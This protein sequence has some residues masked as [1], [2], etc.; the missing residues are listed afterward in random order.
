MS[1]KKKNNIIIGSLCAVVLLMVVG[2]AAFSSVLNIK[3]TSKVSSNWNVHISNISVLQTTGSATNAEDPSW[4]ALTGTFKTNL[5]S[6]GDAMEYSV[7]IYNEGTLDAVLEKITLTDTNNPAIKFTA[8]G[9]EEGTILKAGSTADLTVKVEYLNSVTSQPDNLKSELTITLDY[10]Q[11]DGSSGTVTPDNKFYSWETNYVTIGSSIDS[12][13]TTSDYTTLGKDY[14]FKYNI[15]NAI[16]ESVEMC[17]IKNGMH[18]LRANEYE[19][20]KT[21]LLNIF[22]E[23]QCYTKESSINCSEDGN[24]T[25]YAYSDGS[26]KVDD[27]YGECQ[28][29][30][31]GSARCS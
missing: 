19:T 25:A 4:D 5:V 10:V 30:A 23:S 14:F 9:L 7:E 2:Y 31:D 20:S 26:L 18:C 1:Q 13:E 12:I 3:G 6:P 8:S 17:F 11:N 27:L 24:L 15:N 29:Y 22:G 28:V 21:T 16:I